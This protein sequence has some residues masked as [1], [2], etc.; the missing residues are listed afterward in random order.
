[1]SAKHL[2]TRFALAALVALLVFATAPSAM[3]EGPPPFHA[4]DTAL[5]QFPLEITFTSNLTP[6]PVVIDGQNYTRLS[7][8]QTWDLEN[9]TTGATATLSSTGP[10]LFDSDNRFVQASGSQIWAGQNFVPYLHTQGT[11]NFN[12]SFQITSTTINNH[13][14]VI[15]P[16]VLVGQATPTGARTTPAPWGLPVD[17]LAELKQAKLTPL[18]A[19]LVRHDHVHL[20]LIVNGQAV[21][22]PAGVGLVEPVDFGPADSPGETG[23]FFGGAITVSPLH[24][25]SSSGVIHIESDRPAQF[26]LGQFFA[27]WQVRFNAQCLGRYCTG[28]VRELRVYVDGVRVTGDPRA[29]VL[30]NKQE[31]AVVFGSNFDS[32]PSSWSGGWPT[33]GCGG[34]GEP[35]C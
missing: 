6:T 27:E 25:H 3:A 20:D 33:D 21:G 9:Q 16:C 4:V 10:L 30:T 29:V 8:T 5:C 35:A 32:V 15:D 2:K 26:T 13:P 14:L 19:G 12:S 24:T 23:D 34:A 28:T 22:V 7:G 1:M 11:I 31:I 17:Q 18:L